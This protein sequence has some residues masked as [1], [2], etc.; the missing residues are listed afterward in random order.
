MKGAIMKKF[1][2]EAS[3]VVVYKVMVDA[4]NRDEASEKFWD[5]YS[6]LDPSDIRDCNINF[7]GETQQ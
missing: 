7:I 6:D 3:E 2:I 5:I 1:L 4:K